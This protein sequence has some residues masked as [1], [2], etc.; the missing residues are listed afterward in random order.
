[1]QDELDNSFIDLYELSNEQRDLVGDL[2]D[3]TLEFRN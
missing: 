3:V 2:C 1:M